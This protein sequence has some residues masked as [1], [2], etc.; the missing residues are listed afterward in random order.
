MSSGQGSTPA[1]RSAAEKGT[2]KANSP[3]GSDSGY[4][5]TANTTDGSTIDHSQDFAYGIA[6]RHRTFF[7]RRVTKLRLFDREIPKSTQDRFHDLH[8]LFERPLCDHLNEA[9]INP[10]PISLKLKCW[11]ESEATAKPCIVVLCNKTVSKRVRQ[12]FNQQHIR[13]AYQPSNPDSSLPSFDICYFNRP[14]RS[15]AGPEIYGDLDERSTMCGRVIKVGEAHESRFAT[16]GGV[17][18][19]VVLGHIFP[20]LDRILVVEAC[21]RSLCSQNVFLHALLSL[22]QPLLTTRLESR[23]IKPSG[24]VKLYGMTAGHIL[25]QQPL[26]LDQVDIHDEG[27]EGYDSGEEE[28]ELDDTFESDEAAQDLAT[29]G[30]TTRTFSQSTQLA[31]LWPKIGS[32]FAASN[33]GTTTGQDYDWALIEFVRVADYLPNFLVPFNREEKTAK[34]RPLKE[35]RKSTEDGSSRK[36]FLLSGTGG[37][38]SGTLSTSLSF[39]MM[40]PAKAFAKTYTLVLPHGSSKCPS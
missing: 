19:Y 24:I 20:L 3:E 4:G 36:V 12:F 6:V 37:V 8:E 27:D 33:E 5:S 10:Y 40:G 32:I 13:A 1:G 26:G 15:M 39:L 38:K 28:Y 23:L 14:P 31:P 17:I 35:N 34:H 2:A 30:N 18:R 22:E 16:L 21:L 25:A 29:T 7:E 9:K 11:G